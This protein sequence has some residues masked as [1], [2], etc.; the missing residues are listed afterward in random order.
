MGRIHNPGI[1]NLPSKPG[2]NIPAGYLIH[3]IIFFEYEQIRC[4]QNE[5]LPRL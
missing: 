4:L 1:G 5:P 2:V 3:K